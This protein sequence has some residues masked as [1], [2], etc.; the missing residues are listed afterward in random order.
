MKQMNY[1]LDV[2]SSS[3]CRNSPE[4][5]LA[6][7]WGAYLKL[8]CSVWKGEVDQEAISKEVFIEAKEKSLSSA[9]SAE[10]T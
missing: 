9:L 10:A 2:L 1:A 3:A 8:G 4:E 7:R 5:R 6:G